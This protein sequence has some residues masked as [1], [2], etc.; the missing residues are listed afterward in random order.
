MKKK[1][2][3]FLEDLDHR[4]R[5]YQQRIGELEKELY[6]NQGELNQLM[7]LKRLEELK[8]IGG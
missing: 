5:G 8:F 2:S 4:I 3:K 1:S 6:L 7:N